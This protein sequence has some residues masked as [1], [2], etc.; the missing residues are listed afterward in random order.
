MSR[1]LSIKTVGNTASLFLL[2]TYLVCMAFDL[3]FPQHAMYEA[4]QE[5]LPGFEWLT[6]KGFFI[7]LIESYLYGWYI[8]IVWVL[9]YNFFAK[10]STGN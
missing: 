7:G 10:Q 1:Q 8:A 2:I 3:L 4:W 9:L 5:L 6:W